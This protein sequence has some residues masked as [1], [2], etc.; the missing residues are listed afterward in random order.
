MIAR[1]DLLLLGSFDEVPDLPHLRYGLF[2]ILTPADPVGGDGG[3]GSSDTEKTVGDD[4]DIPVELLVYE[5]HE[6][7]Q[8]GQCRRLHV[9]HRQVQLEKIGAKLQ[10]EEE[11]ILSQGDNGAN[12]VI[13]DKQE[14]VFQGAHESGEGRGKEDVIIPSGGGHE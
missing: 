14:V 5:R 12:A 13:T 10:G 1:D 9:F 4:V 7:I 6:P 2:G 8:L 11:R 3:A